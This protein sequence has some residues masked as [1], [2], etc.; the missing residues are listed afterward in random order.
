MTQRE[1]RS[2]FGFDAH[3]FGKSENARHSANDGFVLG[4]VRIPFES[5]LVAHS[6]GDVLLHALCDALLGAA[7]LGDLGRHYPGDE[8]HRGIDS[9]EL[10]RRTVALVR[11]AGFIVTGTDATIVA[12]RP[13]LAPF[14]EKMCA[15]IASDLEISR[16]RV[17]VK[18][19]S[20]D[21]LGFTG[22]G[23]GIAVFAVAS[24]AR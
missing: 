23:E 24:L 10:L 14:I 18:V 11:Q 13:R 2:G 20:T 9:R 4:G 12:E 5:G 7:A 17:N 22:R 8:R 6:D 19:T 16:D 1:T 3:A 21:G 15:F